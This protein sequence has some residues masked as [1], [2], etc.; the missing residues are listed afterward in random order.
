MSSIGDFVKENQWF[1]KA[2]VRQ[3]TNGWHVRASGFLNALFWQL[4]IGIS[5]IAGGNINL[6]CVVTGSLGTRLL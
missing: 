3:L 6:L 2:A 1:S 5:G 4:E